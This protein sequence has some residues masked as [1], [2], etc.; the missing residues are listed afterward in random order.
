MRYI[1]IV[2]EMNALDGNTQIQGNTIMDIDLDITTIIFGILG[3]GAASIA[4]E[5]LYLVIGSTAATL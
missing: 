4:A 1:C 2:R 3:I 5:M